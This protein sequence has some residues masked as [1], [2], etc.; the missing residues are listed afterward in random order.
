MHVRHGVIARNFD[1]ALHDLW[2]R[3]AGSGF[4][5]GSHQELCS[6]HYV[7]AMLISPSPKFPEGIEDHL[8]VF[9]DPSTV[10]LYSRDMCPSSH[11]ISWCLQPV[12][13]FY[14]ELL[15]H[16]SIFSDCTYSRYWQ[17]YAT[18]P[19]IVEILIR[20]VDRHYQVEMDRH[21]FLFHC[22]GPNHRLRRSL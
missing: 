2:K 20:E 18:Q 17:S 11:D 13:V 16:Q 9:V 21:E 12:H 19:K 5:L 3:C 15:E 8:D 14:P 7:C 22:F 4:R 10:K 1:H 6:P